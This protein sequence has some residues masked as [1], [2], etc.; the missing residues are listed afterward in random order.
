[1]KKYTTLISALFLLLPTIGQAENLEF[2]A[3][4]E[5]KE[6]ADKHKSNRQIFGVGSV[7]A[8]TF[9]F[10]A[11]HAGAAAD[12]RSGDVESANDQE[13]KA[14]LVGIFGVAVG[15]PY[16]LFRGHHEKAWQRVLQVEDETERDKAAYKEIEAL[17]QQTRVAR[18]ISGA[19]MLAFSGYGLTTNEPKTSSGYDLFI[20]A[21]AITN[22]L[23]PSGVEQALARLDKQRATD[24]ANQLTWGLGL[25][26]SLD[27]RLT[28]S[29]A[30]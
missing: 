14:N 7:A 27:P 16:L 4:A 25:G 13:F 20:G 19:V 28:L 29:F 5:L 17:A 2:Q 8:G 23:I 22:L 6:L 3:S 9:G 21:L 12:R 10:F 15:T 18:Y 26:P 1:M 11:F 24:D 30:F